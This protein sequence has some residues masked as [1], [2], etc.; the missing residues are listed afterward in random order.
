[1]PNQA[2]KILKQQRQ[3]QRAMR[4]FI[5]IMANDALNHFKGSFRNQG[6]TDRTIEKWPRR[7]REDKTFRR[8]GTTRA[9]LVR[10]GTLK[11]SLRVS[12][13]TL[14]SV[15][16]ASSTPG[17]YGQVHNEGLLSGRKN[18]TFK[19]KTRKFIGNSHKLTQK[20]RGKLNSRIKRAWNV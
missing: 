18:A 16:I 19:Q 1:M 6:F 17:E 15:T 20:L 8:R 9:I 2:Q 14:T 4:E 5:P 7:K 10:T 11:R 3:L 12:E 13:R